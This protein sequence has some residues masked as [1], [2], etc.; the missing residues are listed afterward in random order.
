MNALEQTAG[1]TTLTDVFQFQ[2][3]WNSNENQEDLWIEWV[4]QAGTSSLGDDARETLTITGLE[5]AKG[6]K[7]EQPVRLRVPQTWVVFWASVDQCVRT[8]VN[9]ITTLP[10]P[11]DINVVVSTC[12]CC[13]RSG[14]EKSTCQMRNEK[15]SVWARFLN[16]GGVQ[17]TC[18]W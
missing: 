5:E 10:T 16:E 3:Q 2:F 13:G 7:L 15:C 12:A 6:R 1:V 11:M 18:D 4:R 9:S 14:H 8:T 17:A